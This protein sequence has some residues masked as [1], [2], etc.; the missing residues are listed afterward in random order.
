MV[1]NYHHFLGDIYHAYFHGKAYKIKHLGMACSVQ[2]LV[3][4]SSTLSKLIVTSFSHLPQSLPSLT[5]L[6][7]HAE[8][9]INL[10]FALL[11]LQT[12]YD[13]FLLLYN[14][15]W[16]VNFYQILHTYQYV[17]IFKNLVPCPKFMAQTEM[18]GFLSDI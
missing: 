11:R 12:I 6:L 1:T 8:L 18:T 9:I 16:N 10:E 15:F 17:Q 5:T 2:N 7:T 4:W 14:Q 3:R 13:F